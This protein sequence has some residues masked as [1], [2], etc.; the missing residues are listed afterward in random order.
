MT[1]LNLSVYDASGN[2]IANGQDGK[3]ATLTGKVYILNWGN[4]DVNMEL[5]LNGI[6]N[7]TIT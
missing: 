2:I 7:E 4:A 3:S 1:G 6:I 5:T